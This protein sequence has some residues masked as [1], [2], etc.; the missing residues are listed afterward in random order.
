MTT[1]TATRQHRNRRPGPGR[2]QAGAVLFISLMLLLML[3][4]IGMTAMN[5][6]TMEERMAGNL[7]DTDL[8][9]QAG[10]AALRNGE[11]W[12]S[13]LPIRPGECTI[14]PPSACATVWQQG[15]LSSLQNKDY[16]WWNT[17]GRDYLTA[18]TDE[19]DGVVQ[20][21]KFIIE[22]NT[23]VRDSLVVGQ[24]MVAG[25]DYYLVTSRAEGG[26]DTTVSVLQSSIVKRFN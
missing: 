26:S 1:V 16:S 5:N 11:N 4:I 14:T 24:S 18:A 12:L 8:A 7:R 21:P 17:S 6:V 22:Y 19:F 15:M 23:Y 25:R 9:F 3:T 2:Q 13:P 10:E 20:D